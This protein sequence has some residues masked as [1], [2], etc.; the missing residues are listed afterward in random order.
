MFYYDHRINTMYHI[1]RASAEKGLLRILTSRINKRFKPDISEKIINDIMSNLSIPNEYANDKCIYMSVDE[2]EFEGI[3]FSITAS[4]VIKCKNPENGNELLPIPFPKCKKNADYSDYLPLNSISI[5]NELADEHTEGG[6]I[7]QNGNFN[8]MTFSI[9]Q[10]YKTAISKCLSNIFDGNYLFKIANAIIGSFT[11]EYK[12]RFF[13]Y[14]VNNKRPVIYEVSR[15]ATKAIAL[16]EKLSASAIKD[17]LL[18]YTKGIT[19][20][21]AEL[22]RIANLIH[23]ILLYNESYS[24]EEL[25]NP[26]AYSYDERFKTTRFCFKKTLEDIDFIFRHVS[27]KWI[28]HYICVPFK[29]IEWN[30]ITDVVQHGLP[31]YKGFRLTC[32]ADEYQLERITDKD[33]ICIN[34]LSNAYVYSS[35]NEIHICNKKITE[36]TPIYFRLILE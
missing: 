7:K 18:K 13:V 17:I 33:K 27:G 1:T 20:I 26:Y 35:K 15:N 34:G 22:T 29:D 30:N 6:I 14:R 9:Y 8:N 31:S 4:E 11:T 2:S 24:D 32:S 5:L 3:R 16:Q 25:N 21:D 12:E 23:N 19:C 36:N 10:S 28:T